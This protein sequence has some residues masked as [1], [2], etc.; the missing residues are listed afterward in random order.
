MKRMYGVELKHEVSSFTIKKVLEYKKNEDCF[1]SK[2]CANC[3]FQLSERI[4]VKDSDLT[5]QGGPYR[6]LCLYVH[7]TKTNTFSPL[8]FVEMCNDYLKLKEIETEEFEI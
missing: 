2:G 8:L 1:F 4:E 5:Y 6:T 7:K 3:P